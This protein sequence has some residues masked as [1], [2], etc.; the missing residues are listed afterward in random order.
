MFNKSFVSL[1]VLALTCSSIATAASNPTVYSWS[2]GGRNVYSD[3]PRGLR[4]DYANKMNIRTH[5]VRAPT[6]I[7]HKVPES[8]AEQQLE[9]SQRMAEQNRAIEEQNA[10]LA[11]EAEERAQKMRQENCE[12]ARTNRK[13]AEQASNRDQILP[14]Y[15]SDIQKYCN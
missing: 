3:T 12:R 15:D 2:E 8:I 13:L 7:K 4:M 14:M 5:T 1:A 9:L 6:E 11:K 10:K